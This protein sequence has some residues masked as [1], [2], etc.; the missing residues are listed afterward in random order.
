MKILRMFATLL[1]AA[2][3]AGLSS[4]LL[5]L[6]DAG[7]EVDSMLSRLEGEASALNRATLDTIEHGGPAEAIARP[8]ASLKRMIDAVP[9]N[10]ERIVR[11]SSPGYARSISRPLADAIMLVPTND[12][13]NRAYVNYLEQTKSAQAEAARSP[14]AAALSA[15]LL[16]LSHGTL[17]QQILDAREQARDGASRA[18]NGLQ[19][20]TFISIG[21]AALALGL[22]GER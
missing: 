8:R 11:D 15:R 21:I 3:L 12:G 20:I 1:L 19:F 13:I 22:S 10:I 16:D 4:T 18:L 5:G 14:S 7:R 9:S 2:V 17:A 6:V